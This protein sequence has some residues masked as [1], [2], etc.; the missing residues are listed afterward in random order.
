[1]L[2]AVFIGSPNR[3]DEILVHWLARRTDLAGVVWTDATAWQRSTRGRL[4]FARARMRRR[5]VLK[6][7]DELAFYLYFH[8][9]LAAAE[10]QRLEE[11]VV[12]PYA[13]EHGNVRW[14]GD[15]ITATGV[16]GEDV[17][18]FLEERRPDL[19]FAMCINER[20]S[21]RVRAIPRHG[22]FLWHEG[23]T[24][25]YRGLYSPFWAVHELDFGR[26]GYTLL[27]MN[28]RFDAGEVFVQGPARDVD[29]FDASTTSR[30]ATRRSGTR[31]RP[32]RRSWESSRP[33]RRGRS[34]GRTPRRATS[35][36]RG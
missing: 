21:E 34:S 19:V 31:C 1:M 13:A 9:R 16:N 30:S 24:P 36:I 10:Q 7:L 5:G 14:R 22:V 3:F 18:A 32:W 8:S 26:I 2:R 4:G 6:T 11:A 25:E 17:C 27:R 33:A 29:P 28:E 20:F 35:R 23:I 15:A 12:A